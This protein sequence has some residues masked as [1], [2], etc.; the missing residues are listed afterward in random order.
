MLKWFVKLQIFYIH[1]LSAINRHPLGDVSTEEY[2]IL[3]HQIYIS[4]S[5]SNQDYD[6]IIPSYY[7]HY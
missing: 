1:E 4:M 5:N 3:I 2:V 6:N 7:S